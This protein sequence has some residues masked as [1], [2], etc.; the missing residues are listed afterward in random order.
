MS[1]NLNS[2]GGSI[3]FT[4][5]F[6]AIAQYGP[7]PHSG[8]SMWIEPMTVSFP[9]SIAVGTRFNVTVWL[10]MSTPANAWQFYLVYN[11]AHLNYI[12]CS[13][14]GN[15]KSLWSEDLP[16]DIIEPLSDAHNATHDYLLFGE[17]LKPMVEKTGLGS[18]AW[19]EFEIV[20]VPPPEEIWIDELRLDLTGV[21]QSVALDKDYSVISLSFDKSIY[22]IG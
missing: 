3:V 12:R 18:L 4:Q 20:E 13:Y 8:D 9:R 2:S 6:T 21:F 14:T 10:N 22:T 7:Y 19:V 5:I 1:T 15:E 16:V 17:V 11:K